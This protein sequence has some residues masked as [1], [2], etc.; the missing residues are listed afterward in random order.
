MKNVDVNVQTQPQSARLPR[1]IWTVVTGHPRVSAAIV[2]AAVAL[3]AFG[4]LWFRPDKLFVNTT[5]NEALPP[6][7]AAP[8]A[9]PDARGAPAPDVLSTGSFRSLEH[10]TDG[11]AKLLRLGDGRVIVRLENFRTSNGPD[12]IVILSDAPA[13]SGDAGAYDNGDFVAI[14]GLK[15]TRGAQNYEVSGSIDPS[16]YQSVV[17]WCRRFNVA[18]GAAPLEATR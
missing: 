1:R 7:A 11:L 13:T 16:K 2:L 18:F 12:V 3:A 14:G 6:T 5:V 8:S 17:I 9:V 15:G 10:E 4:F